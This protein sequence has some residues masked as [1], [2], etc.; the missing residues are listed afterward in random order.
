M[1]FTV[2]FLDKHLHIV[3]HDVPWPADFGG[4]YDL[5]YKIKT[6]HELG[7]RIHL[8][9]FT[10]KR[11]EQPELNA[12]CETVHYYPRMR[13]RNSF[14]L[15][16]PYIV[17]SRRDTALLK[18]LEKDDYPILLD[19]IHCTY[20]LHTNQLP[21]RKV[22][23][24]LHNVEHLY[25]RKLFK[26]EP[27]LVKKAYFMLESILLRK[28]EK[29]LAKKAVFLAVS[30]D[31]ARYY[32]E[33]LGANDVRFLPVFL[34]WQTSPE[35]KSR[36]SYCLYHGNLSISENEKAAEWLLNEVFNDIDVPIVIAGKDPSLPLQTLAHSQNHSCIVVNPS[37]REMQDMIQK[38]QLHVIPSLNQTGVKLKLLN[39]LYNGK[40]CLTNKAGISGTGLHDVC[41]LVETAH[42]YK[43]A[44]RNLFLQDYGKADQAARVEQLQKVYCNEAN[45]QKLISWIY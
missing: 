16:L 45:G 27:D 39:A 31:D 34:P 28:Y 24:R 15:R 42:D 3:T 2:Q 36:G 4:V 38:A 22:F 26:L 7:I 6:L 44:I 37:E 23:V 40:H 1:H 9:C 8:H 5:F 32:R 17:R 18:N 10:G 14:S 11:H 13:K 29:G 20:F 35:Q 19:G 12:Y 41:T 30:E 21:G 33:R 25:Y 43:Q